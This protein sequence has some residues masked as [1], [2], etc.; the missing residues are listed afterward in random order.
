MYKCKKCKMQ[1]EKPVKYKTTYES[2][3]GV[4]DLFM[5]YTPYEY[6]V[7]PYCEYEEFYEIGDEEDENDNQFEVSEDD[8]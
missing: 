8:F 6:D 2:Y 4:S 5:S 7:C 1:F 3:Y